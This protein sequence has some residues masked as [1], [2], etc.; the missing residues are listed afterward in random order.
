MARTQ[1]I[2]YPKI[3]KK[4]LRKAA[5]LF[6]RKGYTRT[7]IDDLARATTSS[8]GALYHYFDSKE[9]I[10]KDMILE[11]VEDMATQVAQT[12]DAT[13]DPVARC[14]AV[15]R[16]IVE[17][18]TRSQDEA[19]VLLNDQQYLSPAERADIADRQNRI[20]DLVIESLSQA[21]IGKRC[22]EHLRKPY[23]MLL[24]GMTNFIYTWY[25]PRGFVDADRLADMIADVYL[26]GF[27]SPPSES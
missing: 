27:F 12:I 4:I 1:S 22:A 3:R 2:E 5:K 6:A 20:V 10:L 18:N 25:N 17:V 23:A 15:I 26:N 16:T 7:T 19:K 11:H 13:E 9:A 24:F 14:R 8:R 21:D